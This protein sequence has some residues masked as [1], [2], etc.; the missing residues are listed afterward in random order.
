MSWYA[1]PFKRSSAHIFLGLLCSSLLSFGV[2]QNAHAQDANA[3]YATFE[4]AGYRGVFDVRSIERE[5]DPETMVPVD[6]RQFPDFAP[7]GMIV[8]NFIVLPRLTTSSTYNDNI[9][10]SSDTNNNDEVSDVY[11]TLAPAITIET[12]KN[13]HPF[14][15]TASAEVIRYLEE[16]D[17]DRENFLVSAGGFFE[18][19]HDLI[20]PYSVTYERSHQGRA[21]N[22]SRVFTEN[23]LEI[24]EFE[25]EGGVSYKPNRLGLKLLGR[26]I[27]KEYED[28]VSLRDPTFRVVRSDSNFDTLEGELEVTYDFHANHSAFI[29]GT[30]GRTEFDTSIFDDNTQ[31][32]TGIFRDSDNARVLAGIVTNYKGILFSDIGVGYSSVNYDSDQISDVGNLAID[33]TLDWNVTRLTTLGLNLG[34]SIVQDNEI[35]QGIVQTQGT[36]SI[37]HELKRNL[38][39]SGYITYLNRDFDEISREDDLYRAGLG[40]VYKPSPYFNISGEIVHT[41]QDSSSEANSFDQNL[42]IVRLTGQY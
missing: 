36:V 12:I 41:N 22:I 10:A 31:T 17:E 33:A 7:K 34:R 38:L 9:F 24:R 35:R 3:E 2:V 28:G 8:G 29:R 13:R 37:D 42:F 6:E 14:G 1:V 16:T 19:K 11:A 20:L 30:L 21:D 26:Y 4:D 5:P 39:L 15:L 18:A 32:S 23:P 27:D 40:V 25:A